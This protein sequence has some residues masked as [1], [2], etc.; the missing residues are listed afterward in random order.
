[1]TPLVLVAG[2]LVVGT[3]PAMAQGTSTTVD[4]QAELEKNRNRRAD[5]AIQIDLLQASDVQLQAE[6]DRLTRVA[7]ESERLAAVADEELAGLNEQLLQLEGEVAEAQKA[8]D[9]QQQ[10][11]AER[12][13]AAY[14][15]PGD[16]GLEAVLSAKD[17]D[18]AHKRRTLLGEVYRYDREVLKSRTQAQEA[19]VAKQEELDDTRLRASQ[20]QASANADRAAALASRDAKTEIQAALEQRIAEFQEEADTL[21]SSEGNLLSLINSRASRPGEGIDGE[22]VAPSTTATTAAP[23]TTT[24]APPTTT[25]TA[26]PGSTIPGQTTVAPTTTRPSTTTTTAPATTTTVRAG[27]SLS[28]PLSGPITSGFGMRWGRMHQGIDIAVGEGTPIRA[29]AGGVA[30]LGEDPGGYG[31]YS[32]IDHGNGVVTVYAHQSS[33]AVGDGQRVTAGSVIGYSGNTGRSTGPHL[34]FEVRIGGVAVD[35]MGYLG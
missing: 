20:V 3:L 31:H 22:P 12:A 17:Y 14:M 7:A 1:M 33:Q 15:H 32:I 18:E 28:W 26:A 25:T 29:A 27:L 34:H 19:L 23:S 9:Q 13:V 10:R 4:P 2:A 16:E 24:T 11:A 30:Y 6:A 5:L 35:P 21:A 8:V